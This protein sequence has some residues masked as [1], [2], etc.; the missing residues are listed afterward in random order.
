[1][2]SI[3]TL[4]PVNSIDPIKRLM[5]VAALWIVRLQSSESKSFAG[6]NDDFGDP[7]RPGGR[8]M[9]NG[10][11]WQAQWQVLAGSVA[12]FGRLWQSPQ[13][14]FG[15]FSGLKR[16]N[17]GK[18]TKSTPRSAK[19][20]HL[21]DSV[22]GEKKARDVRA[23]SSVGLCQRDVSQTATSCPDHGES[24]VYGALPGRY[25]QS[26]LMRSEWDI[27]TAATAP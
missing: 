25:N 22:L 23:K 2:P 19:L 7:K 26:E 15:L 16:K 13:F 11:P 12:G 4:R 6:A 1:M 10:G 24:S 9:G 8:Q 27:R 14:A 20:C 18:L 17:R 5:P 21:D 3:L